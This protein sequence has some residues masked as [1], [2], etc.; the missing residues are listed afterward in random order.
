MA[1][2]RGATGAGPER[3]IDAVTSYLGGRGAS[4]EVLEHP[5][6]YTAME[7]AQAT[8]TAPADEAKVVLLRSGDRY[9]VAVIPASERIDLR[10][11]RDALDETGSLRL[12]TEGEIRSDF[13][14][15]EVGAAPP[16]GPMLPAVEVLDRRLLE[17][18]QVVSAGGDHRH[19]IRLDPRE[20]VRVADPLLAD[21][22]RD[23]SEWR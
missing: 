8:H 13:P 5:P 19:S 2:Q 21:V 17:C 18:D 3:G 15:F 6:T 14:Q 22:C 10:K 9:G 7:E 16:F 23:Y 20:I 12:A 4:Y 11:L 1:E